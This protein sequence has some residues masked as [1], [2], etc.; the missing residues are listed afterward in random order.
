[1]FLPSSFCTVLFCCPLES[2]L[3]FCAVLFSL[4]LYLFICW[5]MPQSGGCGGPPGILGDRGAGHARA[6]SN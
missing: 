5:F 6:D 4:F 3:S 1:M 2:G